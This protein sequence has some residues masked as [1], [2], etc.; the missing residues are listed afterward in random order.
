LGRRDNPDDKSGTNGDDPADS[1]ELLRDKVQ[2]DPNTL[3]E[4][5]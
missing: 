3:K 5:E 2:D 1:G 4:P